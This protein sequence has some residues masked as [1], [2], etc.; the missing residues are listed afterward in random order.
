[1][2]TG[3]GGASWLQACLVLLLQ[4][5]SAARIDRH[6]FLGQRGRNS[7]F[8]VH[9]SLSIRKSLCSDL[10]SLAFTKKKKMGSFFGSCR[11]PKNL[12]CSKASVFAITLLP[13][14]H[15]ASGPQAGCVCNGHMW[16]VRQLHFASLR[17]DNQGTPAPA[18]LLPVLALKQVGRCMVVLK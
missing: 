17:T 7:W 5:K 10:R 15:Y 12:A 1:M 3:N 18:R 8:P 11:R 4:P 14:R 6:T 9:V 2:T 16:M 13:F